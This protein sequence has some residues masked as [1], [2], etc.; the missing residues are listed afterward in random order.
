LGA[1]CPSPKSNSSLL[2]V[3]VLVDTDTTPAGAE[4][5][6]FGLL[7]TGARLAVEAD[8]AAD[9]VFSAAVAPIERR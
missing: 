6:A 4:L 2:A 7:G 9:V 3:V 8:G 5:S 1:S